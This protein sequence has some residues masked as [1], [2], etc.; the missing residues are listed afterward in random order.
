MCL[1]QC[2]VCACTALTCVYGGV[3]LCAPTVVVERCD[4]YTVVCHTVTSHKCDSSV[5]LECSRT[6]GL[7][8]CWWV[9]KKVCCVHE[10]GEEEQQQQPAT[11]LLYLAAVAAKLVSQPVSDTLSRFVL[12]L[13]QAECSKQQTAGE[14]GRDG[15]VLLLEALTRHMQHT[16][17]CV[18]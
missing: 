3:Y 6:F 13:K 18:C 10:C 5:T 11:W 17:L 15:G 16:A 4:C 8:D 2:V 12:A 7:R 9:F 1:F 14:R